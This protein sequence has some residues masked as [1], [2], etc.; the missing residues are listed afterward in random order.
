MNVLKCAADRT[1]GRRV[2]AI[3]GVGYGDFMMV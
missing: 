2:V 3:G 1:L